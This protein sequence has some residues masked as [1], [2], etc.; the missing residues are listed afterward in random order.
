[1]VVYIIFA[2]AQGAPWPLEIFRPLDERKTDIS[3]LW[4]LLV[5]TTELVDVDPLGRVPRALL[6]YVN[7]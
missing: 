2:A 1:M 3:E 7:S 6:S 4:K 5:K